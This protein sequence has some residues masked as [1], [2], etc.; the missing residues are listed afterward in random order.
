MWACHWSNKYA[1]YK[2]FSERARRAGT[3]DSR[4][5]RKRRDKRRE[6]KGTSKGRGREAEK[7]TRM[8]QVSNCGIQISGRLKSTFPIDIARGA[9]LIHARSQKRKEAGKKDSRQGEKGK[10]SEGKTQKGRTEGK[11]KG[12][13]QKGWPKR[14]HKLLSERMK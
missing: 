3:R 2:K 12:A 13:E 6:H 9:R 10:T 8:N 14:L 5:R 4:Q 1:K 11:G 7:D